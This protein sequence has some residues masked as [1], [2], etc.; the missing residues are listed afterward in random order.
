MF[1]RRTCGWHGTRKLMWLAGPAR[2]CD[3]AL[4]PR[5][6][7]ALGQREAQVAQT[8]GRR[9]RGSTRT[10]ARGT[11][12]QGGWRV[13][14]PR[15]SG[16]WLEYWGGN[17]IALNRPLFMCRFLFLFFRVG[18]CSCGFFF[19][20]RRGCTVGVRFDRDDGDRVTRAHAI[21]N[22]ARAWITH[23][24]ERDGWLTCRHVDASRASNLHRTCESSGRHKIKS[25]DRWATH[26]LTST[27]DED[28][29]ADHESRSTCD[30]GPI[31]MR[32][33]PDRRA[34]VARSSR[35]RGPF[36]A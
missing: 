7:A 3:A 17:A 21:I 33:W 29:T 34:I 2:G 1:F 20:R 12:W 15:V 4:R 36:V 10:P 22:Q 24:S 31:V 6:R 14:G 25:N 32:S 13:K 9:P 18:L 27:Y 30:R 19:F 5:G 35:D 11:T 16:P 28:Q 26:G 23:L 8:H